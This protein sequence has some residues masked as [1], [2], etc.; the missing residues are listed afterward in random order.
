MKVRDQKSRGG[1]FLIVVLGIFLVAGS[2]WTFQPPP[3][4]KPIASMPIW[5]WSAIALVLL[6]L[7]F[8]A[9]LAAAWLV[10]QTS[11]LFLFRRFNRS[12]KSEMAPPAQNDFPF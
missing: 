7:A 11:M 10:A 2:L 5:C 6:F 4:W 9:L 12:T 1:R 8:G 3:L